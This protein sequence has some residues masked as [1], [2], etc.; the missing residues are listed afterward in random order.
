[1]LK[2]GKARARTGAPELLAPFIVADVGVSMA[3]ITTFERAD[4]FAGFELPK[5]LAA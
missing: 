2:L 5:R 3:E 1:M 4:A